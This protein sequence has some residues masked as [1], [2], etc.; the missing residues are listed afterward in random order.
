MVS[1]PDSEAT[2]PGY[3]ALAR[4]IVLSS[5]AKT[6]SAVTMPLSAQVYKSVPANLML[7]GG[8]GG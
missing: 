3:R 4:D 7:V 1:A 6:H 2:G 8:R 5:W